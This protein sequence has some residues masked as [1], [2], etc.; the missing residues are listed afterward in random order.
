LSRDEEAD[1]RSPEPTSGSARAE[2]AREDP[3]SPDPAGI[4]D[5]I[6]NHQSAQNR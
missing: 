4:I 2:S 3:E 5:W 6:L 1:L